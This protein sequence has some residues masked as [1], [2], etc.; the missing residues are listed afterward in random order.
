[1]DWDFEDFTESY[2]TIKVDFE[3][4]ENF[5]L[6]ETQPDNLVVTFWGGF[7]LTNGEYQVLNGYTV[8][9]PIVR[10][11]KSETAEFYRHWGYIICGI[12]LL[13]LVISTLVFTLTG[14]PMMIVYGIFEVVTILAHLSLVNCSMPGRLVIFLEAFTYLSRFD[15]TLGSK[16]YQQYYSD[17]FDGDDQAYNHIFSQ[18]TYKYTGFAQNMMPILQ[19]YGALIIIYCAA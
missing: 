11:I 6:D 15:F 5:S 19:I 2:M 9:T 7:Y 17:L 13:L 12:I 16:K 18:A 14:G 3:D 4:P 8:K 1:M 10:Q